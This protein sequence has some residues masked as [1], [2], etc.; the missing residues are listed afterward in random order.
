MTNFP[1]ILF[2]MIMICIPL[3]YQVSVVRIP[4]I[5]L[6]DFVLRICLDVHSSSTAC[7]I[8]YDTVSAVPR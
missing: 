1:E 7:P 8:I 2:A 4:L 5:C 6:S 3:N